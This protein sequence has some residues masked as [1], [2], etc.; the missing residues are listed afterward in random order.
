MVES[1]STENFLGAERAPLLLMSCAVKKPSLLKERC[2][3]RV[4]QARPLACVTNLSL[5]LI[6]VYLSADDAASSI[7]EGSLP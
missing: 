6:R 7:G 5:T 1:G 2:D 3:V 4:H